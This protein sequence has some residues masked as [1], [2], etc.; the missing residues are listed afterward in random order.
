M[1]GRALPFGPS[2]FTTV[3]LAQFRYRGSLDDRGC[4]RQRRG[5]RSETELLQHCRHVQAEGLEL[6]QKAKD[7]GRARFRQPSQSA[8]RTITRPSALIDDDDL[9]D[10]P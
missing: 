10:V 5:H 2:D 1:A 8:T 4:G 9:V 7:N 6:L 3:P